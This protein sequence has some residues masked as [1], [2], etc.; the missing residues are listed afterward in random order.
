MKKA[1]FITGGTGLVGGYLVC[2]FL[3]DPNVSRIYLLLRG[4]SEDQA[5][6]KL[7][8]VIR[9]FSQDTDYHDPE[10]KIRILLGD[11]TKKDLDL[12]HDVIEKL[13][14]EITHIIHSAANVKFQ[15][16]LKNAMLV[17]YDGTRNVLQFAEKVESVSGLSKYVYV[18]TAYTCGDHEGEYFENGSFIPE[19]F[20]NSYEESKYK[21]ETLVRSY[22]YKLPVSIVRPS[23]IVGHSITGA[24]PA[25]NGLYAPLELIFKQLIHN[26]PGSESTL[27]DIVPVDYVGNAI[28]GIMEMEEFANGSIYHI[29]AG[30]NNCVSAGEVIELACRYFKNIDD[31]H[32]IES[33]TYKISFLN[34]SEYKLHKSRLQGAEVILHNAVETFAPYINIDRS[35]DNTKAVEALVSKGIT[36]PSFR[37][38]FNAIL[39]F[40]IE[41]NW[42][43]KTLLAA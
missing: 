40:C 11:I 3:A 4:S 13:A 38:Y 2:K 32:T 29:T 27:M 37:S 39:D 36:V 35:F 41:S 16:S 24:T 23:I 6:E 21:S 14:G 33:D 43:R 26:V 28:I 17:N 12:S 9:K 19:H 22:F 30:K 20:A 25:F 18:S 31:N 1:I 34:S 7:K 10:K 8:N 5:G 42:G 15:Q